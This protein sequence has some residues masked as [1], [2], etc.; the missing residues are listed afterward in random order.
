MSQ[1]AD[2][3]VQAALEAARA[4]P[5]E[6]SRV[7]R[8]HADAVER[9]LAESPPSIAA[10]RAS[11]YLEAPSRHLARLAEVAASDDPERAP[12]AALAAWRIARN[13]TA[14]ALS[15]EELSLPDA[16][17]FDALAQ[18]ELARPDIRRLA[19]LVTAQIA[20]LRS[21]G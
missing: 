5:M 17:P 7:V 19:A 2:G 12:V 16:A 6:L 3:E 9:L 15:A 10:V 11:A 21:P 1:T 4:E 14:E 8:A 13:L 20:S 18:D